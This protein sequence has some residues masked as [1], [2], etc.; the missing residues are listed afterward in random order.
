MLLLS[1]VNYDPSQFETL[2]QLINVKIMDGCTIILSTPQRIMANPFVQALATY[3]ETSYEEEVVE[4]GKVNK[5]YI[6][7]LK[8]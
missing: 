2:L 7:V 3:L 6:L 1:D 8:K 4:N 5:I